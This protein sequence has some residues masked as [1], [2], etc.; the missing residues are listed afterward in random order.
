MTYDRTDPDT[1]ANRLKRILIILA[2]C[3]ASGINCLFIDCYYFNFK[4]SKAFW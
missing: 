4:K 1:F 3:E 2:L